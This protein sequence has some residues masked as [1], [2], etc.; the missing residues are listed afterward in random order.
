[1][2]EK[3][4]NRDAFGKLGP[5]ADVIPVIMRENQMINLLQAGI[6]GSVR[7]PAR[8]PD[9][10]VADIAGINQNRFAGRRNK[11][12]SISALNV[13]NVNVQRSWFV[14]CR[15]KSCNDEQNH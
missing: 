2:V 9:S 14:L 7:D 11:Q 12:D 13:D 1:M 8:I 4:L 6:L 3:L 10:T 15:G 5:P